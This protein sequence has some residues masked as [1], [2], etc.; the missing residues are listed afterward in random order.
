MAQELVHLDT[1]DGRCPTQVFTPREGDGPWP[2]AILYMDAF[3]VRSVLEQ[4][5]Q[6]LADAG[7]VVLLPDLFYRLGARPPVDVQ[8][9]FASGDVRGALGPLMASTDNRRAAADTAAFL[10]HLAG[11]PDVV[12]RKVG[13]TGYC[14]GGA[15][16]LTVA[17]TY[18][19]RI[20]AAASFH[21][22]SLA[23]DSDLSPHRLVSH[24][25]GR[26]YVGAADHDGSYPPAMALR[27]CEALMTA[28][29]DHVHEWYAGALH[30]WT[31]ADFPIYEATAAQ[32]HWDRLLTLFGETLGR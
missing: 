21:G 25:A 12:G 16:A 15:V 14:M 2:G 29:V 31:M 23:T 32:R 11:R 28:G 19:E 26:V 9:V 6:R 3:G 30:G 8:G 1:G 24:I 20:A 13:V 10:D 18:P 5:A 27:L 17:G 22:G 4:M 7:Y